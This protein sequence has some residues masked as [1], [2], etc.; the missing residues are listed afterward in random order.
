[1]SI[2]NQAQHG[3]RVSQGIADA[4]QEPERHSEGATHRVLQPVLRAPEGTASRPRLSGESERDGS[5][6]MPSVLHPRRKGPLGELRSA[7][8][9][10]SG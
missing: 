6:D 5:S 8:F 2:H 9:S 10:P 4:L 7:P 1:M 3:N